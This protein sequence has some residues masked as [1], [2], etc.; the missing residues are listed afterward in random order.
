M[1]VKTNILCPY[2]ECSIITLSTN[3]IRV[4][5]NISFTKFWLKR[6]LMERFGYNISCVIMRNGAQIGPFWEDV[7]HFGRKPGFFIHFYNN[8]TANRSYLS[9]RLDN[10]FTTFRSTELLWVVDQFD[11]QL[12]LVLESASLLSNFCSGNVKPI[13]LYTFSSL[14]WEVTVNPPT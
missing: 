4:E 7:M 2:S 5:K 13:C 9:H 14:H 11:F 8:L 10:F 6:Y 3:R 12:I 1:T